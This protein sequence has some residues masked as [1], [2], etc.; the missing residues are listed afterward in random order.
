MRGFPTRLP[1]T[2]CCRASSP[3]PRAPAPPVRQ[4][5]G[6]SVLVCA[7][8][9]ALA[10]RLSFERLISIDLVLYG[11]SLLLEFVALVVLRLREPSLVR[12]FRIPGGLTIRFCRHRPCRAHCFRPLRRPRRARRPVSRPG[13][14]RA[15]RRRRSRGLSRCPPWCVAPAPGQPS[16]ARMS[17]WLSAGSFSGSARTKRAVPGKPSRQPASA[18]VTAPLKAT[19]RVQGYPGDPFP[20]E[21]NRPRSSP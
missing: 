9:W 8:A 5:P 13:F 18:A 11:A 15:G 10:L 7:V 6:Q 2:V 3:A 12:P 20:P 14:C 16:P 4:S 21:G 17:G 1:R 19:S